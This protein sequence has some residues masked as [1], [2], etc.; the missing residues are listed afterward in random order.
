LPSPKELQEKRLR[1]LHCLY[2]L[3]AA[4]RTKTVNLKIISQ[5]AG[6]SVEDAITIGQYFH[7]EKLIGQF[8]FR[9][10]KVTTFLKYAGMITPKELDSYRSTWNPKRPVS[11]THQGIKEIEQALTYPNKPTEHFT[12]I[13]INNFIHNSGIV[14]NQNIQQG[15]I[16]SSQTIINNIQRD[17][18]QQIINQMKENTNDEHLTLEQKQRLE[19][20]V[21]T[22]ELQSK[23]SRPMI[24]RIK[25]SLLSAKEILDTISTGAAVV[26]R[27]VTWISGLQLG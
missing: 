8:M 24:Q 2:D 19:L 22:L 15:T 11:I 17:E 21:A 1:F 10:G 5:K 16:D 23:S 4:D 25:E 18:L 13:T 9:K 6:I 26:A 20:E 12:S 3:T 7:D 14:E 27:I